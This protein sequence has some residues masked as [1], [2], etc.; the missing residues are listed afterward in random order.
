M[1]GAALCS[2]SFNARSFALHPS[3]ETESGF[4]LKGQDAEKLVVG[5]ESV[6]K[7]QRSLRE[8]LTADVGNLDKQTKSLIEDIT[9]LKNHGNDTQSRADELAKKMQLLDARISSQVRH[10]GGCPIQR[11]VADEEKR[12]RFNCA[13]RSLLDVNGEL[14]RVIAAQIKALGMDPKA[15]R[16]GY[17]ETDLKSRA[18]G[19]DSSPGSTLIDD[20][21]A[22]DIYDTLTSFGIWNTFGVR[23]VG[24]K[25]TKY[26]L[27]TARP[28]AN[29]VLTEGDPI[30][31]D[32]N[33]AGSSVTLEIE[34]LAVL[35]NVSLQLLEDSE[36]DITRDVLAD[37]SEALAY[38]LDYATVLGDGTAD[39]T[40]GGYTGILNA[41]TAAT[42]ANGNVTVE[43]TDF[44]D[45][46]RVL[47]SVDPIVLSR[48]ARWWMHPQTLVRALSVKD[49]NKRPL[50]QTAL[51][52]P[53]AGGIGSILGYPITLGYVMPTTNSAGA[54]VAAFGDPQSHVVGIRRMFTQEASDHHKW[55][56]LQRSFRAYGRAGIKTR[57]ATGGAYLKLAA[58]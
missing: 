42:S 29:F 12:T 40:N 6:V 13:V 32:T 2:S 39:A 34:V 3:G 50:F 22:L 9:K 35:L 41:W 49:Q 5:V 24:T 17:S 45:W 48:T 43:G 36:F 28:V 23:N 44:E 7:E 21:L 11:I 58:A 25:Q 55:S 26:P 15:V 46:T 16:S 1:A 57:S 20:A 37:F 52:A 19:E 47:L 54:K 14:D 10:I 31:D 8:Q 33:K 4:L 18:L 27:K 53:S 38:R 56:N 30:S 51:E